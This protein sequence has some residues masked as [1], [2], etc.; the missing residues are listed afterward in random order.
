MRLLKQRLSVGLNRGGVSVMVLSDLVSC[1]M[2]I[3]ADSLNA[4]INH[5]IPDSSF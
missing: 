5:L 4:A 3:K 1:E 2:G